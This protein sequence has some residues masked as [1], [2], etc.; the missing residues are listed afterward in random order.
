MMTKVNA[1]NLKEVASGVYVHQG[2]H[3]EFDHPR[4]DD[5]ANIGFIIGARCVA[6]ID[7]GGS[8][9]IGAKLLAA[10][11]QHSKLP[12]C[13]VINTHVHFDHVLGN[14][15]FINES[16]EFIGH[17]ELAVAIAGSRDFFLRQFA[18]NLGDEP[19]ARS[20]V[21]PDKMVAATED[22]DL[23]DRIIRLTAHQTAHSH[24]DLT[25][26]DLNTQ[27]LWAGDLVFRER[28]PVLTGSL[29]GWL[30]VLEEIEKEEVKLIIPGHGTPSD[31]WPQALAKQQHYLHLL[32]NDT[33][34][35]IAKA[36]LME[37]AIT[38][39]GRDEQLNWLLYDQHHKANVIK[40]F[41]ELEWE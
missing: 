30:A 35:A 27:T 19:S 8:I 10:I 4:Q 29:K 2:V 24:N 25:I 38:E 23:G 33:R 39:I 26:F 37:A 9:A 13:Y 14:F 5:I 34:K 6:V 12:I 22:L 3:V 32:L 36:Q 17:A 20:I 28:I 11:R 15:A 7:T 18:D 40:A 16:P 1:F 41:T 21:G 31:E